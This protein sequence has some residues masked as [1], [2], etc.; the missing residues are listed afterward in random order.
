MARARLCSPAASRRVR[1]S[2]GGVVK[3]LKGL[4][5]QETLQDEVGCRQQQQQRRSL[6]QQTGREAMLAAT[7]L[8]PQAMAQAIAHAVAQVVA[9]VMAQTVVQR[10]NRC[11][12]EHHTAVMLVVVAM[13]SIAVDL[14]IR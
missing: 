5:L 3:T 6:Q 8:V 11:G 7:R 14:S 13:V 4:T 10:N 2:T 1:I 9:Q 12:T